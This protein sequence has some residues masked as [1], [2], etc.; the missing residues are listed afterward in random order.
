MKA[1]ALGILALAASAGF[2]SAAD[3]PTKAP[4]SIEIVAPAAPAQPPVAVVSQKLTVYALLNDGWQPV[5][6]ALV[7]TSGVPGTNGMLAHT[8]AQVL[9]LYKN[10]VTVY[11]AIAQ[12]G[13][14]YNNCHVAGTR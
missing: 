3:Y 2:A 13:G 9:K 5:D 4:M 10:G 8:D 7:P 6:A 1:F 12:A 14:A 11:C